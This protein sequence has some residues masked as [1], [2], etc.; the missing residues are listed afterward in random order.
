MSKIEYIDRYIKYQIN[1]LINQ[2]LRGK[3][4]SASMHL[5]LP[6]PILSIVG[7]GRTIISPYFL[8]IASYS[9]VNPLKAVSDITVK[10]LS[11]ALFLTYKMLPQRFFSV[12]YSEIIISSLSSESLATTSLAFSPTMQLLQ[13][14]ANF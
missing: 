7:I 13:T 10:V 11:P 6:P 2:C 8:K 4:I 9:S 14:T 3:L 12:Y 5:A 1:N